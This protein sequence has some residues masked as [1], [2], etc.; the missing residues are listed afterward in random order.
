M[1]I[2]SHLLLKQAAYTTQC[3]REVTHLSFEESMVIC[4]SSPQ[5]H[6]IMTI[7]IHTRVIDKN[8]YHCLKYLPTYSADNIIVREHLNCNYGIHCKCFFWKV[9]TDKPEI[10]KRPTN[11]WP[12]MAMD[13][14]PSHI[15]YVNFNENAH[16]HRFEMLI[17]FFI[18]KDIIKKQTAVMSV[19]TDLS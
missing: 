9:L 5:A 16:I 18:F 1:L 13:Q 8:S 3:Y 15:V 14:C 7:Y 12:V 11:F 2:S 10:F 19:N 6:N 4:I 17:T